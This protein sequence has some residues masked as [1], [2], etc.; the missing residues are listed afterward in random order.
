MC[1]RRTTDTVQPAE[2]GRE[3]LSKNALYDQIDVAAFLGTTVRTLTQW[4]AEGA[5]PQFRRIRKRVV[6][7]GKDVNDWVL[8]GPAELCPSQSGLE[9]PQ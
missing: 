5:G 1:A 2:R 3:L 6:Y 8:K 9:R 7:L 4:R